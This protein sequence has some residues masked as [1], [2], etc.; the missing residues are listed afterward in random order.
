MFYRLIIIITLELKKMN[1]NRVLNT[2]SDNNIK[3]KYSV[4]QSIHKY[5]FSPL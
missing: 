3:N 5:S 2:Q 1:I 4:N